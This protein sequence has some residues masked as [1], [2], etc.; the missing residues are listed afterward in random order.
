MMAGGCEFELLVKG[1]AS[2]AAQPQN[3]INALTACVEILQKSL[4]QEE[5]AFDNN[6]FHLLHFG[7]FHS[8]QAF[9]IIAD[10]AHIRGSIRYYDPKVF[11]QIVN[12]IEQNTNNAIKK[13]KVQ[14][15]FKVNHHYPP[16]FNN[17]ELFY[18]LYKN[19]LVNKLESP[20]LI[21]EDFGYYRNVAP[22]IFF[23]LGT[24][25]TIPLHSNKFTF[26]EDILKKGVE[27]YRK[28]LTTK[29][30]F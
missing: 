22:S 15:N 14:V 2:H 11:D 7:T 24:G 4:E 17:E 27:L 10:Q 29:I 28:L 18:T 8:G 6:T 1:K 30:P 12:I 16:V 26:D 20:V 9:N 23:F 3:G 19:N 25:D 13:Y 21:S 5:K